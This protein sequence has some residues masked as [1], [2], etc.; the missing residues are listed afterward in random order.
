MK[1][2]AGTLIAAGA[3][4]AASSLTSPEVVPDGGLSKT[5]PMGWMSWEIFRC[6]V[7]C[8]KEQGNCVNEELYEQ[9]TDALVSGGFKDAVRGDRG[10]VC[11]RTCSSGVATDRRAY[12]AY[13]PTAKS[14]QPLLKI[15]AGLRRCRK[16]VGKI[17]VPK[18]ATRTHRDPN[19]STSTT[20]GRAP[21]AP[22][23]VTRKAVLLETARG[24]PRE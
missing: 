1:V 23:A 21:A 14:G 10:R 17:M 18:P 16:S 3:A 4:A 22:T 8:Q 2:V 6:N 5:P 7:D 24:F 13:L 11:G 20:A 15:T 12:F 19:A 9:T